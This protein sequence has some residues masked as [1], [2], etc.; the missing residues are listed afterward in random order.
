MDVG[1]GAKNLKYTS[2]MMNMTLCILWCLVDLDGLDRWWGQ[3]EVALQR[4]SFALKEK[5][6]EIK[7]E[8]DQSLGGVKS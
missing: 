4:N 1:G 8:A 5:E 6:I 7:G 3:K 2:L